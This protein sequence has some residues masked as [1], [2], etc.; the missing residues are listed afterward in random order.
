MNPSLVIGTALFV[1]GV[2]LGLAQL[3]LAP[4]SPQTFV[5][6]EVTIGALLAIVVVVWFVVRESR[7]NKANRGGG[8]LDQ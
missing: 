4:W 1:A 7:E 5:K 2:V 8:G 6:I 3:W